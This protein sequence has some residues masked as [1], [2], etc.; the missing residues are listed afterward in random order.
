MNRNIFLSNRLRELFLDGH[1]IANTNYKEK[2]SSIPME[3]AV[4]TIDGLNSIAALVF[5]INYYLEGLLRAFKNGR[6][7]I[8][9][10]FSFLLPPIESES[11]WNNLVACFLENAEKF[12]EAIAQF[13]DEIFDRPFIEEKYGT[14]LRNIEAVIEHGYYH[15][16]QVTLL[17]KLIRGGN[18]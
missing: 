17:A 2:I 16:G 7:D 11:D 1:W 9:D 4:V 13:D 3:E 15:L 6:L 14:Y 18:R 10:K 5:H 8:S 12:I